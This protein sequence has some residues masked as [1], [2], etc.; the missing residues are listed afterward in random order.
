ME[1]KRLNEQEL[2]QIYQNE[3]VHDFPPAELKP[4][5]AMTGLLRD[6]RYDPLVLT[7]GDETLG[8]AMVWLNRERTCALLDYLGILRGKRNGG[9][10][11]QL[12][13]LLSQRYPCIVGEAEAP[14]SDDPAENELRR[15]RLGFY[16][17]NGCR[18]LNYDCA[19]FGVHFHCLSLGS[20]LPDEELLKLHRQVYAEHFSPIH[21]ERYIQLPLKPGEQIHQ[22]A[23]W[24]EEDGAYEHFSI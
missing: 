14:V 21:M 11:A 17:R 1:L 24:L 22:V 15:R 20:D 6:H 13:G 12:L 3:M 2:T 5:S 9:L 19:L 23:Q 4:L 18:K 7:C 10:G 8:Y 16:E